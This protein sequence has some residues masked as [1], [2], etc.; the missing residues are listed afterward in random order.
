MKPIFLASIVAAAVLISACGNGGSGPT[1][2][3]TSGTATIDSRVVNYQASGFSFDQAAVV[4]ISNS[5]DILPDIQLLVNM[6]Q[7][8][9]ILGV[10]L[11]RPDSIVPSFRLLRRFSTLD[12]AQ[13]YFDNLGE[14]PDTT[15]EDLALPV[16]VAEVWAVK[17]SRNTFAKI[18]I[19]QTVAY[20]DTSNP[21]APTPY[22]QATFNWSYQ[23]N[24]T[25]VF[26]TN[27]NGR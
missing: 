2:P 3:P 5:S 9:D 10:Y 25:R 8:G 11:A 21:S 6:N 20:M 26:H 18:L 17:T 23:P 1:L 22:G 12:S 27:T 19:T 14:I 4:K 15:Y 24:G 7:T 16:N 13:S